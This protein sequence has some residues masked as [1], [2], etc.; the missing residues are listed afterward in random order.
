MRRARLR[1]GAVIAAL[2]VATAA[3]AGAQAITNGQLDGNDHPSVGLF[4]IEHDG[5]K[6][7]WCSASTRACTGRIRASG[8]T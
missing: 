2:T 6:E 5:I 1:L 8:S 3:A 4:A 7:A